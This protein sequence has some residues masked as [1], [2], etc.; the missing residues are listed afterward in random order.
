M[1]HL[2]LSKQCQYGCQCLWFFINVHT[3]LA[4]GGC[5][6]ATES[7]LK[8]DWDRQDSLA[9][10]GSWTC[11]S[12]V[13]DLMLNHLSHIPI[14]SLRTGPDA[15]P[16]QPHSHPFTTYWTWYSTIYL[17]YIPIPLLRTGPDTQPS[18][19]VPSLHY[20]LHQ[21]LNHLS[22]IP[23][24]SLH[25]GP[26]TQPSELHS[27]PFT[28][29]WTWCW[30]IWATFQSLHYVLDLMFNH[31]SYIPIP[32]LHTGPDAEPSGLHFNP[33]NMYWIWCSTIWAAFPSLHYVLDL[34]HNHLSY[35]PI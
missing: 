25:T 1:P 14:P 10:P 4:Q 22:Y 7:A 12:S 9:T 29:Y 32:S 20:V 16:S 34:M 13:L 23:I 35:I 18:E 8:V 17:S 2:W 27:H 3:D 19:L 5:L 21:I 33:F 26:D 24:P 6:K 15:E 28:T 31:L 11:V 30:T